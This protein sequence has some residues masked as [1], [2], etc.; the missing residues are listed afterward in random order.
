MGGRFAGYLRA[1]CGVRASSCEYPAGRYDAAR[2]GDCDFSPEPGTAAAARDF[3]E[4][5]VEGKGAADERS[6][7]LYRPEYY[8]ER[9]GDKVRFAELRSRFT[10]W[11]VVTP[12]GEWHETGSMGWWGLSSETHEEAVSWEE[13]FYERFLATADP[14]MDD[15]GPR[16][17]H[18][19]SAGPLRRSRRMAPPGRAGGPAA[20]RRAPR[21]AEG[22]VSSSRFEQNVQ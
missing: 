21:P 3:W 5:V 1:S 15:D 12:D 16:L 2:V 7:T 22:C 17:P 18:L 13:G 8:L 14:R 10:T 11:A 9:Y 20:G 19:I 6:F 4:R